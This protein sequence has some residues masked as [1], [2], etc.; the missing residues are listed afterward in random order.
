MIQNEIDYEKIQIDNELQQEIL[1]H[2]SNCNNLTNRMESF[3][4]KKY[5]LVEKYILDK[6]NNCPFVITG[7]SGVGKST[8]MAYIAKKVSLLSVF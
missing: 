5:E 3:E 7:P 2:A 8:L 4:H 6:K 1:Q